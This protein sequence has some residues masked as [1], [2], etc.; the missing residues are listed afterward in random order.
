MPWN[1]SPSTISEIEYILGQPFMD[2]GELKIK[3][4]FL[5]ED[6]KSKFN[7]RLSHNNKFQ[8]FVELVNQSDEVD[9]LIKLDTA[10]ED[11]NIQLFDRVPKTELA[12][13]GGQIE[14]YTK[15]YFAENAVAEILSCFVRG[16]VVSQCER[17]GCRFDFVNLD[18]SGKAMVIHEVKCIETVE[19]KYMDQLDEIITQVPKDRECIIM[20][21][22]FKFSTHLDP[23][24]IDTFISS[25][26]GYANIPQKIMLV[27]YGK[28][29]FTSRLDENLEGVFNANSAREML[30]S[31]TTYRNFVTPKREILAFEQMTQKK[32][33]YTTVGESTLLFEIARRRLFSMSELWG[34]WWMVSDCPDWIKNG[35][36]QPKN[37]IDLCRAARSLSRVEGVGP[38]FID[39]NLCW[40]DLQPDLRQ[41]FIMWWNFPQG[42]SHYEGARIYFQ[43]DEP[44]FFSVDNPQD[45]A[46]YAIV[47]RFEML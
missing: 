30:E 7:K 11:M 6:L 35:D 40:W 37:L 27:F 31:A 15:G 18:H 44:E 9:D 13:S 20:Y 2:N 8:Y 45:Y 29:L 28:P 16:S 41:N 39:N 42:F 32:N 21:H 12:R 1:L 23:D 3:L 17:G 25:F 43:E 36:K 24:W 26:G 38:I 22:F 47:L 10:F 5:V 19:S 14:H 46:K 33:T 4:E 34:Q